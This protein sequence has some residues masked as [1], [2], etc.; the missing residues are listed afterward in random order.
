M[1]VHGCVSVLAAMDCYGAT[2]TDAQ[3]AVNSLKQLAHACLTL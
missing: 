3:S 2:C 1:Q